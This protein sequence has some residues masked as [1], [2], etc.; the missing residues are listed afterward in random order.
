[1]AYGKSSAKG[2]EVTGREWLGQVDAEQVEAARAGDRVAL[3][4]VVGPA[5]HW[6]TT[7]PV[8]H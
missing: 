3:D 2:A 1:M 4:A 7:S 5:C 6:S 8:G